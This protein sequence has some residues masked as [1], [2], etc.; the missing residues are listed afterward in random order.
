[1]ILPTPVKEKEVTTNKF[2][3]KDLIELWN[4]KT[5]G[6]CRSV[7]LID[8]FVKTNKKAPEINEAIKELPDKESWELIFCEVVRNW[9]HGD[10]W[11]EQR[12]GKQGLEWLFQR[13][14]KGNG[15]LNWVY[16]YETAMDRLEQKMVSTDL[17]SEVMEDERSTES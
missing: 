15:E 12:R 17:F 6:Y 10:G 3:I 1:M 9:T 8:R 7:R 5:K 14:N 11:W 16:Y 2:L 4:D 13:R